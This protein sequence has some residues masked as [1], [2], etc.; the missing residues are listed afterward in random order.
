MKMDISRPTENPVAIL[1]KSIAIF[2]LTVS[3]VLAQR[4][5]I[6]E[7]VLVDSSYNLYRSGNIY[8]SGQPG[9]EELA[10]LARDG[11]TLVVNVRTAPEMERLA[12]ENFDE[13]AYVEGLNITYLQAGLGGED[14]YNPEVIDTISAAIAS[15]HGKVLIHCGSAVRATMAWM[16]WLVRNHKCSIDEAM[17]LGEKA[18]FSFAFGELLGFPVTIKKAE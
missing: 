7:P 10:G 12:M 4:T 1:I 9:E 6:P 11:V 16:A 15:A 2:L 8:L 18:R 5:R 3:P 17:K 14:G 13:K